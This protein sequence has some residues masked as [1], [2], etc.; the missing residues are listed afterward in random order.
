[1]ATPDSHDPLVDANRSNWDSRVPVHLE[2]AFYDVAGF[3][4]RREPRLDEVERAEVGAVAGRSLLHLQCHIGLDTISWALLGA[5]ATGVDFS[6]PA[7]DA[8]RD[9][10]RQMDVDVAFVQSDVLALDLGRQFDIVYASHGVLCWIPDIAAWCR[11]AAR[12]VAPGGFLYLLD[13]HPFAHV[14]DA[15]DP[16][17]PGLRM[18]TGARYLHAGPSR[19]EWPYSY[20]SDQPIASPVTYQ[21]THAV[22]DIVTALIDAGLQIEFLHE[23]P[24][25]AWQRFNFMRFDGTWWR[26]AGD[27]IPL[28]LSVKARSPT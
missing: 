22:G 6:A 23:F 24:F 13:G 1:M 12:H 10:A 14:Y 7:L 2:S 5:A 9:I 18:A 21:W 19:E 17:L 3:I 16:D 27:P 11:A 8:A 20:A 4:S 25:D 26:I 15:D 28:M